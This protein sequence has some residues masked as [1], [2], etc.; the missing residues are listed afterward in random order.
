MNLVSLR[1]RGFDRARHVPF[2]RTYDVRCS[3]CEA[4]VICGIPTHETGCPNAT[5]ECRGCNNLIPI[6]ETYCKDCR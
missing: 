6:R 2:T 5:R 4:L 3:Q 1:Q